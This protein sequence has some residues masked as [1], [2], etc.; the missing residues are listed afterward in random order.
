MGVGATARP[1]LEM[2]LVRPTVN[3]GAGCGSVS[4]RVCL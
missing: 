1:R 3:V 4:V 2:M